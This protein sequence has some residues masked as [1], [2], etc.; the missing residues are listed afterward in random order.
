M[1]VVPE[2]SIFR[3]GVRRTDMFIS[4]TARLPLLGPKDI[5]LH[6]ASSKSRRLD[7]RLSHSDREC[8]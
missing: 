3:S 2:V 6:F 4:L 8:P 5:Q 1:F 7:L